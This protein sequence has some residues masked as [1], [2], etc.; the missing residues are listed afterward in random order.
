MER[1]VI[2]VGERDRGRLLR[3]EEGDEG[4]IGLRAE[5]RQGRKRMVCV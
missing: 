4:E 2:G 3:E 5:A 1:L